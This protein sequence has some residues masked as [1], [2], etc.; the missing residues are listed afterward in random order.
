MHVVIRR[1][2]GQARQ[3]A[4]E[5]HHAENDHE[6]LIAICPDGIVHLVKNPSPID[7]EFPAEERIVPARRHDFLDHS[8]RDFKNGDQTDG[9]GG[10]C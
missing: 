5:E 7:A 9:D 2:A 3:H 8:R 10:Y 6:E 4:L 1:R